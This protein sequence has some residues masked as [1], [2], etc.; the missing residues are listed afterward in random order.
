MNFVGIWEKS[1]TVKLPF[2]SDPVPSKIVVDN[3]REVEKHMK[4]ITG[5]VNAIPPNV[6][7]VYPV[8]IFE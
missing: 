8:E 5:V 1:Q 2:S 7:L 3:G 6:V 4:Y